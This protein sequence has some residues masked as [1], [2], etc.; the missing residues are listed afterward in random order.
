[1]KKG[2]FILIAGM[3]S[4]GTLQAQ[5]AWQAVDSIR[6][7]YRQGHR[8][9]DPSFRENRAILNHFKVSIDST[10]RARL[11]ER[12][13]IHSYA[14][15]DGTDRANIRLASLRA[16]S[17]ASYLLPERLEKHSN[18]IAWDMLRKLV[19]AS[20][21]EYRDEVLHVLDHTPIWIHDSL[22]RI[23]DGRKKRLMELRGGN[24]YRYMYETFF[25]DLRSSVSAVLYVRVPV[26][27]TDT[28]TVV[29]PKPVP[30][31]KPQ[32][33]SKPEPMQREPV[34]VTEP[35]VKDFQ[36]FF[37]VKTNLL[38]WATLMPD[39]R[40]YTFV[41]NLEIEWFFKER[42]SLSGTGNF[43]K[44]AYGDNFLGISSWSLE[45]RWWFKEDG[46]FHWFYLGIYGQIGD[47]DVQNSRVK[48][49]GNTG[50]LW[51][52]GLSFG[53]AIPFLNR[54]GFEIGIRGGYRHSEV[55]TY[56]HEAPDY[57]LDY[58][59]KNNHWGMT[60]IKAS[61]YFRFGKGTK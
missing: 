7:F 49:D 12:V 1:M 38:Y 14:S 32:P 20:N 33:E 56:S 30:E 53:A 37:A 59:T 36:P 61:F 17:L 55:K 31:S 24:P 43:A 47:Y 10:L 22:G 58:E 5:E 34:T 51:G 3:L 27:K 4:L 42:W 35:E 48:N 39:F 54:L 26:K 50:N 40:S 18:G 9:V 29:N 6:I 2:L 57:F 19:A 60:G 11:L 15:P 46:C 44:W 23:I 45:P 21:M 28:A 8:Y 13:V 52:A 25:P 16:D 41:P